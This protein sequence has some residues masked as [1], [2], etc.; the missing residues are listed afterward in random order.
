M[1]RRRPRWWCWLGSCASD[2]GVV[3]NLQA[4]WSTFTP[5]LPALADALA[6]IDAGC[7]F[8]GA[9]HQATPSWTTDR[10]TAQAVVPILPATM[11]APCGANFTR[12]RIYPPPLQSCC[13]G[14]LFAHSSGLRLILC[15]AGSYHTSPSGSTR[16]TAC[17]KYQ[18]ALSQK[19]QTTAGLR[20]LKG[21]N[22]HHRSQADPEAGGQQRCRPTAQRGQH[23]GSIVTAAI[24]R[25]SAVFRRSPVHSAPVT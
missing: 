10:F 19:T 25:L 11:P 17:R 9:V 7:Q 6:T 22:L 1:T 16:G 3:I 23:R 12:L 24:W 21:R 4:A 15:V 14:W 8:A 13:R 2:A 18:R 5:P 20:G